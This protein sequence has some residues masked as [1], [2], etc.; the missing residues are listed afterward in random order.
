MA[1]MGAIAV[2]YTLMTGG[3]PEADESMETVENPGVTAQ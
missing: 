3:R 2:V 1:I